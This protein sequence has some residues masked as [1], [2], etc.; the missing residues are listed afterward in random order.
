[1]GDNVRKNT[2]IVG[3]LIVL[4]FSSGYMF[5]WWKGLWYEAIASQIANGN[6]GILLRKYIREGKNAEA[7]AFINKDMIEY[8]I[9]VL[10]MSE[11]Q[12]PAKFKDAFQNFKKA[13][14]L[15]RK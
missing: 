9:S 8:N 7:L 4:S 15:T 3:L 12:I 5:G 13:E 14:E 1:M 6:D 2:L 11:K 10:G